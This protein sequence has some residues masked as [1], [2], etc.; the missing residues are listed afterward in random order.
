MQQQQQQFLSAQKLQEDEER[1]RDR[2]FEHFV[3]KVNETSAANATT[4]ER[5]FRDAG[6]T[7]AD[8]YRKGGEARMK[9]FEQRQDSRRE[10][11]RQA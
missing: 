4:R 9:K 8:M 6:G 11:F 5:S 7:Q 2:E 10:A 3:T 1:V